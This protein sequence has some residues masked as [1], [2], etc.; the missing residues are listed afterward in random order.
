MEVRFMNT[1]KM[2]CFS[3]ALVLSLCCFSGCAPREE[4]VK[5]EKTVMH[6]SLN[7]EI[8]VVLDEQDKVVTVNALNEE[9]NL[10]ISDPAFENVEGKSAEEVAKLFIRVSKETGYLI[11]GHVG[12]GDNQISLSISGDGKLAQKL[13]GDVKVSVEAYFDELDIEATLTQAAALTEEQ[14]RQALAE[15]APY[16]EEAKLK[17]MEHKQLVEELAACR[18]ETAEMYSQE[19]K[20]AYYEAKAFALEQAKMEALKTHLPELKQL[21]YDLLNKSYVAGIETVE[22]IRM[23]MLVNEDS[24]YQRALAELRARKAAFLAYRNELAA[25]EPE[26]VTEEKKAHLDALETRLNEAEENL[27]AFAREANEQLDQAKVVMTEVYD[28][29][30]QMLDSVNET[31][32]LNE[33]SEKQTAALESF[34]AEFESDYTAAKDAAK[35]NWDSMRDQMENVKGTN[36]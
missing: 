22:T 36:T 28:Q 23:K 33:I 5:T 31:E 13:Y 29:I 2:I 20:K 10:I 7:P 34:F 19:L 30:K 26:Q 1:R 3:L 6:L 35:E 11:S 14:L 9:G 18:K 24:A 21:T 4:A 32:I 17:A 12:T 25:M 27:M 15:C 16:I 8:E